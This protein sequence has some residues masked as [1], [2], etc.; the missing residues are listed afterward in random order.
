MKNYLREHNCKAFMEEEARNK[1]LSQQSIKTIVYRLRDYV[2]TMYSASPTNGELI[3]VCNMAVEIFPSLKVK[4]S[5]TGGIVSCQQFCVNKRL[6]SAHV[7]AD[8]NEII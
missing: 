6:R 4:D 5:K 2:E 7:S 3:E 1:F 8:S